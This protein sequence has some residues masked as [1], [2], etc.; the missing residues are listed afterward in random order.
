MTEALFDWT[1]ADLFSQSIILFLFPC[2][3][4][5]VLI[6][7]GGTHY[8][9]LCDSLFTPHDGTHCFKI[10]KSHW[11]ILSNFKMN[12]CKADKYWELSEKLMIN[13]ISKP[14]NRSEVTVSL[15]TSQGSKFKSQSSHI[16]SMAVYHEKISMAMFPL[17]LIQEGQLSLAGKSI[18]TSYW[19]TA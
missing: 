7:H 8:F 14:Q 1:I 12:H 11:L 3:L 13:F 4:F 2:T 17:L 6:P 9:R 19:L 15:T 5:L 18:C 16:T 10:C